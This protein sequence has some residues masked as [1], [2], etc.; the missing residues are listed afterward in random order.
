V[1]A[2]VVR[3]AH[4]TPT[5][6]GFEAAVL[7][8]LQQRVG[9][10]VAFFSAKGA[11]ASPTAVGL[12]A[13]LI[14]T[15]VRGGPRYAAELLPV[16]RAALEARG[17]AVDTRVLGERGVHRS[18]YYQ[19]VA[20]AVGGRHSLMAYVPLRG[21][22][23]AGIMLGRCGRGAPFSDAEIEC[24]E[25]LLPALGVARG[26]FGL[27]AVCEPLPVGT[28]STLLG[29]LGSLWRPHVLAT[30]HIGDTTI[31]VRDRDG[32]REMVACENGTELV[33]TRASL[34]DASASGW[35]YVELLHIAALQ[36]KARR[37][38]L[39][40]GCGGGVALRQF[41]N[42]YPGLAIDLVE[43]EAQV[44][45]LAR[46]WYGL[47]DI[48]GLAVHVADGASFVQHAPPSSWD[49]AVIDAFDAF[50]ALDAG[51][52]PHGL[53]RAPFF[54]ALQRSLRPGG[55]L[56]VN[57]IGTLDGHGPVRDVS[58]CLKRFFRRIRVVPVMKGDEDYAPSALRNVVLIASKGE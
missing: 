11:E 53:L 47:D 6:T 50:D 52:A 16:K 41:A 1:S 29:R 18:T 2:D 5:A 57:V 56:A 42:L 30:E 40:V 58:A 8:L 54:A 3:L 39:F 19:E 15:A 33:W 37:R 31:R 9:F 49:V 36:A 12:D 28:A 48:P 21:K 13:A 38:A 35:P 46:A 10:D 23:V 55:A 51:D 7:E 14:E 44:V 27:P 22:V 34:R 45:E 17:V 43:R 26:S 4:E 32:Y 24:V 20:R 25:A